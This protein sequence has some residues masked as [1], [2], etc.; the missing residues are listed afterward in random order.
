N[1]IWM[2]SISRLVDALTTPGFGRQTWPPQPVRPPPPPPRFSFPR[3]DCCCSVADATF[4]EGRQALCLGYHAGAG[5]GSPARTPQAL[6]G[7]DAQRIHQDTPRFDHPRNLHWPN[8]AKPVRA[9]V[10]GPYCD[11]SRE[12]TEVA[13]TA[14]AAHTTPLLLRRNPPTNQAAGASPLPA[15][16]ALPRLIQ[17]ARLCGR[18]VSYSSNG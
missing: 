4:R 3:S 15:A 5:P 10:S 16:R 1:R 12:V 14:Q 13:R 17:A 9:R 18:S 11:P 7:F 8:S 6:G 2:K